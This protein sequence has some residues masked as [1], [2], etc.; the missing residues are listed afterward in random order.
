[1]HI[2][3]TR[4]NWASFSIWRRLN[5]SQNATAVICGPLVAIALMASVSAANAAE[6][7]ALVM[8][9][10]TYQK[11][12]KSSV[13]LKRANDIAD[14]LRSRGFEVILGTDPSN[15]AAR[16]QLRDF[17]T[18]AEDAELA[19]VVL[20]GHGTAWGG[21]SF[22]LA[23]NTEIG[24][25]PDLL[26]RALS[27]T[28]VAQIAGRARNGGVFFFMT[29]PS[30]AS[31]IDGLDARP[32]F[33]ADIG[34]NAFAVFS[35]SAKVPISSVDTASDEAAD[36]FA[37]SL[38]Q[39]KPSLVDA[40]KAAVNGRGMVIGKAA[41][42]DLTQP[43]PPAPVASR[44]RPAS[45]ADKSGLDDKLEAE[46][47][48]RELAERRIQSELVK[49]EQAQAEAQKARADVLKAQ[50]DAKK[51]LADAERAQ[52]EAR[53][54]QAEAERAQADAE[55]T[56]LEARR[57]DA[58][59]QLAAIQ[60]TAAAAELIEEKDL[61]QKQRLE[62]QERL[63]AMGLYTGPLDSIMGPL[64]REAI[65][66]FQKSRGA[67]VTGYLTADQYDLLLTKRN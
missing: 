37:R 24:R 49:T 7:I 14:A 67:A 53:R 25:A 6:R 4:E 55:R 41:D 39:A 31:P 15:A 33:N 21:Q 54:A 45:E 12:Q 26:S 30:F 29:T 44:A 1:M 34:A 65:M 38:R 3:R 66:G 64:T 60:P 11:F 23:T 9:A 17:S 19:L 43:P 20:I 48:A 42:L 62:I 18:K 2:S 61:G 52:A 57:L 63:R 59:P 27:V 46:R 47:Q 40:V 28:N 50:A 56:K 58:Q 35:S 8:A 51:A 36:A 16:A 22:Y 13:G 32:Q 5:S 10:E